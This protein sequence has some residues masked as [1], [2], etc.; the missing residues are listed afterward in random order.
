MAVS[1]SVT[2]RSAALR[3]SAMH[4]LL[5]GWALL[6]Y[7][8]PMQPKPSAETSIAAPAE[9]SVRRFEMEAA[10]AF[11][12]FESA[13]AAPRV[14]AAATAAAAAADLKNPRLFIA[15]GRGAPNL[16]VSFSINFP[17]SNGL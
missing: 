6:L 7:V 11:R 16:P 5:A 1:N 14:P 4:S 3:I 9:P 12:C 2:P 10:G 8:M 17:F 13:G 15:Q